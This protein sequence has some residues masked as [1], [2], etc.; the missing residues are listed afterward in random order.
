MFRHHFLTV[1]LVFFFSLLVFHDGFCLPENEV[2]AKSTSQIP[3]SISCLDNEE[4][5]FLSQV[6][7]VYKKIYLSEMGKR[8][9]GAY[10]EALLHGGLLH[11]ALLP[12]SGT[13]FLPSSIPIYQFTTVYLI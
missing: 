8:A 1:S 6:F 7:Q 10:H 9:I 11:H 5:P 2:S 12:S 13:I 4:N 3:G